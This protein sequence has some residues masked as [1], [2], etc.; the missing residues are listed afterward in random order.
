MKYRTQLFTGLL[1]M[2][3]LPVFCQNVEWQTF[4]EK[5][6]GIATPGYDETID[7]IL[8]LDQQSDKLKMGTFGKSPQQRDLVYMIYDRDG[9]TNPVEIRKKGRIILM[10]EACIHAGE[11][12]GKDAMLLLLR[13]L[14]INKK[15][16]PFFDNV[17]V[18]F[19]P[20]FNVDGHE[21]FGKF[22]RINQNG[23]VEMGWR[24][25]AQNL[26]LNR[27]FLKADALEMKAWLQFYNKWQP[28][29]F[30]DTHTTDGADYQYVLTYGLET[31]ENMDT[32]INTWQTTVY[33]PFINQMMEKKNIPI[34][35]YVYF[36]NWHDPRSG[37]LSGV[38]GPMFSQGYT[39]TRN[40]P[41]LLVETH[42]LKPYNQRVEATKEIMLAT[43]ELL[44]QEYQNLS[45]LIT[46]ADEFTASKEFRAVPF[47]T[48][49]TMDMTDSVLVSFKGFE[50]EV[51]K[52]DLSGGDWF[53]YDNKKPV[54]M[55][56][57]MFDH[58]KPITFVNLPEAY[59]IPVEWQDVIERLEYHGVRMKPLV[60]SKT[61]EVETYIFTMV[62]WQE[63]PYEGRFKLSK[64]EFETKKESK[65]F[66]KG[67]MIVPMNQPLAK[68]IAHLLEPNGN[69][70]LVEWG[71]FNQI[72]E[73]KE[74]AES[75]VME[76]LA[77]KMLD[78]IPGLRAEFESKKHNDSAFA[79]DSYGQ[80]N[81]FYS[82]TSWWDQKFMVY[83][84]SRIIDQQQLND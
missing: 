27:D 19:V 47:P 26:N 67:S 32:N 21:R 33:L 42:M 34:F 29:F 81:W 40:R 28:E 58:C 13:D 69:G 37:L 52:S 54:T 22:G 4:Y 10:V 59:V 55:L 82:K 3:W 25:T 15:D 77:R 38:A 31:G 68:V 9:L 83:P 44:N 36:R 12:E 84:I 20:I 72:F 78:S 79:M 57:P 50:Y 5:S 7:F 70:S 53:I 56:L 75:Y 62:D 11:S 30:I 24:T 48:K 43:I 14:L 23:P 8:R 80:L 64:M 2:L 16:E 17:S 63:N 65:L 74:Y 41:G 60:E 76:P 18:L 71:L 61:I 49:F 39:A 73:Q 46:K 66:P 51:K 35:P 6:G 1:I 45:T